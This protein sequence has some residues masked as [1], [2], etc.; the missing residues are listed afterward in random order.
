MLSGDDDD[1]SVL[2]LILSCVVQQQ[3]K[4]VYMA[5]Q[6]YVDS[7]HALL[8]V[9]CVC[10]CVRARVCMCVRACVCVCV[11]AWVGVRGCVCVCVCVGG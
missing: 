10:V 7:H 5:I 2:C 11:R 8:K 9:V 6:Q 1:V 4:F 3:Y